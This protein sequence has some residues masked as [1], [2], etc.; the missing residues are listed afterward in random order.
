MNVAFFTLGCKVNQY[1][2]E[3][4]V[5]QF[6]DNGFQVV[7][8]SDNADIYIINSCTVTQSG[9]KK[10]KQI[11]KKLKKNNPNAI[12]A[13][14]GCFSQAF[15]EEAQKIEEL[16]VI[17]GSNNK[18]KLIEYIIDF[19]HSSYPR[20][21]VEIVKNEKNTPFEKMSTKN[22]GNKTRAFVKI[23]DGCN[24]YCSYCIIPLARGNLRSKTLEDL[25]KELTV[26]SEN[27]YKEV[28]LAGINL[29][30]YGVDIDSSLI[31]AIELACSISGIERVRLSSLEPELIT[32]EDMMRMNSQ[33]KFCPQF[34]LSLQSGCDE[35]LRRMKR[36]YDSNLYFEIVSK[37]RKIFEN[38]SI[39]TD[40]MVGFP[41]ETEQEFEKSAE[42]V[43]KVEFAKAHIFS[44]S[45]RQGTKA[46]DMENQVDEKE[47]HIRHKILTEITNVSRENF[48]KSQIDTVSPILFQSYKDG[49]LKGISPNYTNVVIKSEEDL[50]KKIVNVKIIEAFSDYCLGIK[51]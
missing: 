13:L 17:V 38:P 12:M 8:S 23:Q 7:D 14:A 28:V 25:K 27:N 21:I 19:V 2:T 46:A 24:Q 47:K 20:K 41:G 36:K 29:S 51:I 48:L 32:Q 49:F 26:L 40:V 44:Y 6:K 15:P 3:V 16:D 18:T 43:K 30:L 35:T 42:F 39:T 1:E 31:E 11:I 34:H 37:I 45:I 5:N 50:S 10:T 4:L 22:F 9:D 33:P